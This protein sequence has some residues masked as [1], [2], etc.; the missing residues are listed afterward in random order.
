MANATR[1]SQKYQE[2]VNSWR[3]GSGDARRAVQWNHVAALGSPAGHD[4]FHSPLC[5]ARALG[6]VAAGRRAM[7]LICYDS[8]AHGSGDAQ[9]RCALPI[10]SIDPTLAS[11]AVE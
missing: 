10:D 3:V 9:R 5:V 2:S 1:Q 7:A 8:S 11:W 4:R 6:H